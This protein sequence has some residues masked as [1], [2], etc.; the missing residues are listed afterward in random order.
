LHFGLR[1]SGIT[2]KGIFDFSLE[3]RKIED[4]LNIKFHA[5]PALRQAQE[6]LDEG[7]AYH[8]GKMTELR[9]SRFKTKSVKLAP[10]ASADQMCRAIT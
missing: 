2:I 8:V 3:E 7:A 1:Q 9:Q 5:V 6:P 10:H 4:T